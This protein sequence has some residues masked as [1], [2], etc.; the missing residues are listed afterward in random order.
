MASHS[1]DFAFRLIR[2]GHLLVSVL[3][4]MIGAG[5]LWGQP[6]EQPAKPEPAPATVRPAPAAAIQPSGSVE[7]T[8]LAIAYDALRRGNDKVSADAV[9]EYA[10]TLLNAMSKAR[11]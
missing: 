4:L 8:A 6:K 7:A 5:L 10:A 3:L 2:P 11:K 1:T 9:G